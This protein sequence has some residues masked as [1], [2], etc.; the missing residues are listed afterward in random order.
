MANTRKLNKRGI[1]Y[2]EEF[3]KVINSYMWV[4]G[5]KFEDFDKFLKL[6]GVVTPISLSEFTPQD[7][8]SN[9]TSFKCITADGKE[10]TIKLYF[11]EDITYNEVRLEVTEGIET[12]GYELCA[13]SKDN[14][15][16]KVHYEARRLADGLKSLESLYEDSAYNI[17]FRYNYHNNPWVDDPYIV[18]VVVIKPDYF[19]AGKFYNRVLE[20]SNTIEDYIFKLEYVNPASTIK[21]V[22]DFLKLSEDEVMDSRNIAVYAICEAPTPSIN[23]G[24]KRYSLISATS[25]VFESDEDL[26]E[27]LETELFIPS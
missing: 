5:W 20:N 7:S 9:E 3:D 15:K 2:S 18:K 14:P 21:K 4:L 27:A 23:K 22:T 12:R 13:K 24:L 11:D 8:S 17:T 6:V 19:E 26:E 1:C 10:L 25:K 16:P